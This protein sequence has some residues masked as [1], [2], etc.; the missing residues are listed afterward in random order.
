MRSYY[1]N[2]DIVVVGAGAG[3]IPAALGAAEL[4]AKV[5]L[6]E[7]N[8]YVGGNAVLGIPWLGF[9]DKNGRRVTGGIAQKFV[10]EMIQKG[11]C[12]NHRPCP[13]NNS[14]TIFNPEIYK[15]TALEFLQ[16]AN[17]DILLHSEVLHSNVENGTIKEIVLYGKGNCV[18]VNAEIFIDATGDGD[19]AYLSGCT[20]EKGQKDSGA[21]Q[22]P[23]VMFTLR[24]VDKVKFFDY[25]ENN[26][27]QMSYGDRKEG[28]GYGVPYFKESENYV[29]GGLHKLFTELREKGELPIERETFIFINGFNPGEIHVNS[30]RLLGFD[31]SNIFELTKA[32]IKGQLQVPRLIDVLKKYVPGFEN[33]YLSSIA[34]SLGVRE[35]RRFIGMK[36][37]TC[38]SII[39]GEIPRDTIALGAY[40]IDIPGASNDTTHFSDIEKPFG[41]PYGCLVSRDLCNLMYTGRM[42]SVDP[43]VLGSTRVMPTCMAVGEAAGVG[44]ALAL[45]NK[46]L[47][48]KVSPE[49]IREILLKNGGILS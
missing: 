12:Y 35:T 9:L 45:K 28:E 39:R 33:C 49:E 43:I 19:L 4:G 21:L 37:L 8:G 46:I 32:E 41:I 34:P 10:D 7:K 20:Y 2:Y 14:V 6:V 11:A 42:I 27:D 40:K 24:G 29:F 23:T 38:D 18:Y 13:I 17:V 16:K 25:L 1:L 31:A 47:P 22:P 15:L 36:Y 3:G 5:L 44:A 48:A 30:I 26:P